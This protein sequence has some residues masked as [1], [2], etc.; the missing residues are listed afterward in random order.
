MKY[1]YARVS[2]NDQKA[3]LQIAALKSAGCEHIFT[4][5]ASG[6]TSKRPELTRCLESL[7]AGDTLVVWKL[8][9]LGRSLSHLVEVLASL[10]GKGISFLSLT[11][12]IDTE[13]AAGRLLGHMLAALA[14]FERTLIVERTQAGLKAAKKRGVKLGRR[15][16]LSDDQRKHAR[17]LLDRGES[18]ATVAKLLNVC[19]ATLYNSLK[20]P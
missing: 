20:Q 16:S 19:R 12:A 14:E 5:T 17:E 11:E 2:T 1:G 7:R 4:D 3:D 18:P 10:Q 9:R 6:A 13:S 15:P 8:D